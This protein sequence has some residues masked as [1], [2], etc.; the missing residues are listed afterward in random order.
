MKVLKERNSE[1]YSR[2]REKEKN[3]R[4]AVEEKE[5]AICRQ[6][7]DG[8]EKLAEEESERIQKIKEQSII[9]FSVFKK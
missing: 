2:V 9:Y 6:L 8:L 4:S 1:E 3:N 5:R 7:Y